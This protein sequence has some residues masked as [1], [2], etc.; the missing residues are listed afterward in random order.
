MFPGHRCYLM[1]H[2]HTIQ[3]SLFWHLE[4][5]S[6]DTWQPGGDWNAHCELTHRCQ[7]EP[8]EATGGWSKTRCTSLQGS[9]GSEWAMAGW[10]SVTTNTKQ[11]HWNIF[12]HQRSTFLPSFVIQVILKFR[13]VSQ[14][15]NYKVGPPAILVTTD[16]FCCICV[17]WG[18][19]P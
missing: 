1:V 8:E 11:P 16:I 7:N 9:E 17:V 10:R 2:T 5:W 4:T 12:T 15:A 14:L 13:N 19:L 18:P 6:C 3:T